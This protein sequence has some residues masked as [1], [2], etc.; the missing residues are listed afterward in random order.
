MAERIVELCQQARSSGKPV[1]GG[2]AALKEG[3]TIATKLWK[4][5]LVGTHHDEYTLGW[6]KDEFTRME[7]YSIFKMEIPTSGRFIGPQKVDDPAQLWMSS[8]PEVGEVAWKVAMTFFDEL[9]QFP[10]PWVEWA[11]GNPKMGVPP[12]L[13]NKK[14][15][16]V[17]RGK[18]WAGVSTG[19]MRDMLTVLLELAY[20]RVTNPAKQPRQDLQTFGDL[21]GVYRT[22]DLA[23]VWRGDNRGWDAITKPGGVGLGTKAD[24]RDKPA[25]RPKGESY[26]ERLNMDKDW[27]PFSREEIRN[28][29]WYRK[30]QKDNDLYTVLS[31]TRDCQTA[32]CFPQIGDLGYK[33]PG[34]RV[35]EDADVPTLDRGKFK[36]VMVR[37]LEGAVRDGERSYVVRA[38]DTISLYLGLLEGE[39]FDTRGM[40]RRRS[41]AEFIEFGAKQ[42]KPHNVLACASFFRVWHGTQDSDGFTLLW[43]GAGSRPP[44]EERCKRGGATD[45]DPSA[46]LARATQEFEKA[47]GLHAKPF[48]WTMTGGQPAEFKIGGKRY[49]VR[50]MYDL[51]RGVLQ[52]HLAGVALGPQ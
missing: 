23:L 28:D 5:L 37:P 47:K 45:V 40:Q 17:F 46:L 7:W 52:P 10:E 51:E 38:V 3:G 31:V 24:A 16:F 13:E 2:F 33:F 32:A 25:N 18:G 8:S 15:H 21:V 20:V 4:A 1:E 30:G 12:K 29:F 19:V 41:D 44:T 26:A 22:A 48:K 43:N 35:P 50:R 14:N 34:G 6:R 49:E 11:A 42:I 27:H 39:W 36:R 9:L